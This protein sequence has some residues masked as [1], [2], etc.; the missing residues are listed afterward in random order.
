MHPLGPYLDKAARMASINDRIWEVVD[1]RML[2][3]CARAAEHF[4]TRDLVIFYDETA[5]EAPKVTALPR[6][7]VLKDPQAPAF[8]RG[9]IDRSAAD[10]SSP[11]GP[12]YLSFWL[13][14][15]C[16]D[17]DSGMCLAGARW[18]SPLVPN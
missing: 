8:L 10:A 14:Y 7:H 16:A 18:N 15:F 13:V 2:E 17:G 4:R 6:E 12:D 3:A 11:M 1:A 5:G 9:K